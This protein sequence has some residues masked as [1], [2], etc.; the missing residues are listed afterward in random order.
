MPT[1]TSD[2]DPTDSVIELAQAA[3][4]SGAGATV[5]ARLPAAC[6]RSDI[7][8]ASTGALV[9]T[10]PQ[11]ANAQALRTMV[12]QDDLVV[13]GRGYGALVLDGFLTAAHSAA[14]PALVLAD[15]TRIDAAEAV[16]RPASTIALDAC[17]P[18]PSDRLADALSQVVPGAGGTAQV[19]PPADP[20]AAVADGGRFN[21]VFAPSA[22][23]GLAFSDVSPLSFGRTGTGFG[24]RGLLYGVREIID[25]LGLGTNDAEAF[26]PF[27]QKPSYAPSGGAVDTDA[28]IA[29]EGSSV[30]LSGLAGLVGIPDSRNL[31][32]AIDPFL[33]VTLE[34]DN[35]GF[36]SFV[37]F[38]RLDATGTVVDIDILW[39]N[40]SLTGGDTPSVA[41]DFF[42][43]AADR[44]ISSFV[45]PETQLGFFLIADA[46]NT[47]PASGIGAANRAL[48][49]NLFG[50]LGIDPTSSSYQANVDAINAHLRYNPATHLV[51]VETDPGI[52]APLQGETYFS[53][54]P[55]LNT[56]YRSDLS[57]SE[58][59][60]T[61]SGV[62]DGLLWIGFEDWPL[63]GEI[64]RNAGDAIVNIGGPPGLGSDLDYNDLIFSIDI[65][66]PEVP[67]APASWQPTTTIFS[68]L[69]QGLGSLAFASIVVGG[70]DGDGVTFAL[71]GLSSGW[72]LTPQGD[73]DGFGNGSYLLAPPGGSSTADAMIAELNKITIGVPG[74]PTLVGRPPVTVDFTVVDTLGH[75]DSAQASLAFTQT[76]PSPPAPPDVQI[77]ET[78]VPPPAIVTY[79]ET[80]V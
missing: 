56:D 55:T 59:A 8:V 20:A 9:F 79:V 4:A 13:S 50:D 64:D 69:S 61:L 10:L 33:V 40:A 34:H 63:R 32:V 31:S 54:D 36:Q 6:T 67:I 72:T 18:G 45:P 52:F 30:Y 35:A 78:Y 73:V 57:I 14:P 48:L 76:G 2:A 27:S 46:G 11:I 37:G 42:G 65:V 39:L 71:D 53:H 3:G 23:D 70:L 74:D 75:A 43:Q 24:G 38:Y 58:N 12:V 44:T 29:N 68:S 16:S 51:E 28:L 66:Y 17:Q 77:F 60:H 7:A 22:F 47:D 80:V 1:R 25:L 15:G 41:N 5:V 21:S 62:A 49:M 19:N 26:I